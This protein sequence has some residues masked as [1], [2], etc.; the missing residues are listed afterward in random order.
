MAEKDYDDCFYCALNHLLHPLEDDFK[1]NV[2]DRAKEI[3]PDKE[4]DWLSLTLGWAIAKGLE[5]EKAV[6]FAL[7]IRYHTD[8]G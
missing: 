7:H 1:K 6:E 3:D 8:L 5:P 4:H 2:N